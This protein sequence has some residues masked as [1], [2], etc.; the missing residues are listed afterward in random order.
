[1]T[2][3]NVLSGGAAQGLVGA[4]A[5]EFK[6]RTG[7]TVGGTFGAV[8]AMRDKLLAGEPCDLLILSQTLIDGLVQSGHAVATSVR[9]VG[10]VKTGVAVVSGHPRPA[11]DTPQALRDALAQASAIYCP[12]P[13]KA[14]AGIHFYKVLTDLGLVPGVG[15]RLRTFPNGATAM[16]ALAD[17]AL[18][19]AIGS[20]QVT[21]ILYT[22]GVD[23]IGLLPAPYELSTVYTAAIATGAQN[24]AAAQTLIDLLTAPEN[25][26][27]RHQ[28]GF[29]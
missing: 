28:G 27:L 23:L 15:Q 16:R 2:Q 10:V 21:E 4:L 19:G 7:L 29:D 6:T 24:P 5:S 17:D 13:E 1:M 9:P 14:P 26:T 12:D 11:V 3:L 25:A 18:P 20:T 22:Q 8:G